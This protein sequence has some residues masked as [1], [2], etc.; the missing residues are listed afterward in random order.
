MK[1]ENWKSAI[2]SSLLTKEG[3]IYDFHRHVP[4]EAEGKKNVLGLCCY[5]VFGLLGTA[6]ERQRKALP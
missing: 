5:P 6:A 4:S 1:I 2:Q 3:L